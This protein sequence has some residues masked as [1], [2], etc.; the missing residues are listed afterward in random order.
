[1]SIAKCDL[2]IHGYSHSMLVAQVAV[3]LIEDLS[4]QVILPRERAQGL[5][6]VTIEELV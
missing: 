3:S 1:M 4:P 2:L 6:L 5:V